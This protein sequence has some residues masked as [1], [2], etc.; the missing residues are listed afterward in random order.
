[1]ANK[2]ISMHKIRQILLFLNRNYSERA[3]SRELGISRI[4]VKRYKSCFL[5]SGLDYEGLLNLKDSCLEELVSGTRK[6]EDKTVDPRKS[7]IISQAGY[8]LAELTRIG[9]TRQLLWEEYRKEDPDGYGYSRFCELLSEASRARHATMRFEHL[10]GE[11]TEVDFAGKPLHYLN[12]ETGELVACPVLVAVLPYSGYGYLE[13]L[14]NA[15]LEQLVGGLNNAADYFGGITSSWKS[16]NMKQW[17]TRTCR[18]EP[19]FPEVLEQWASHNGTALLACRPGKPKDKATV[20]NHVHIFYMRVYATLRN[21]VFTSLRELNAAIREQLDAHHGKDFQK[22]AHSRREVFENEEKPL[23]RPLPCSPY[24]LRHHANAKVQKN[25]HVQ[26]GEDKHYY[27][28]PC[29]L[30]GAD[31]RLIYCTRHV[32][33]FHKSERVAVHARSYKKYGHTTDLTHM[34]ASHQAYFKQKGW[35]P[36]YYLEQAR[37]CGPSSAEYF[38]KILD[39]RQV[40]HQAYQSMLGLLRLRKDFGAERLE[41]ACKRALGGHSYSYAT[42]AKI[43]ENNMDMADGKPGVTDYTPPENPTARGGESFRDRF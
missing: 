36:E 5:S 42:V 7:R 22:R 9:V 39:S 20:E 35:D 23:L 17:V 43:L 28:V 4:T 18:Y 14:P 26:L 16:D 11:L 34:P 2:P 38:R 27:S 32:E 10:P 31:T 6:E 40:V 29:R 41:A 13:A 37:R 30:I 8:Y 19:V 12:E 24:E 3:T 25:Y 1:M 33:I 21:R 15:T